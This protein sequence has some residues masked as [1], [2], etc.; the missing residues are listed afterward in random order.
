MPLGGRREAGRRGCRRCRQP[1]QECPRYNR[2][3]GGRARG[4]LTPAPSRRSGR[5]AGRAGDGA[6]RRAPPPLPSLGRGQ[7]GASRRKTARCPNRRKFTNNEQPK[8]RRRGVTV[9]KSIN[10][11]QCRTRPGRELELLPPGNGAI[12]LARPPTNLVD[13]TR[14]EVSVSGS[15]SPDSNPRPGTRGSNGV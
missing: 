11:I 6:G 4:L 10:T 1:Q 8:K 7:P 2:T 12:I 9:H 14:P 15:I 13:Q 3:V 5:R